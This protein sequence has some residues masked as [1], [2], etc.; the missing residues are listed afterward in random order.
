MPGS[1]F[2]PVGVDGFAFPG[3]G[4]PLA[5]RCI[6]LNPVTARRIIAGLQRATGPPGSTPEGYDRTA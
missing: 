1:F 6:V 5:L 4:G 2:L 3:C